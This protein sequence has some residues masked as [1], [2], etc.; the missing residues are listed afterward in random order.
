MLI[1]CV[2]AEWRGPAVQRQRTPLWGDSGGVGASLGVRW[3]AVFP[4]TGGRAA[5]QSRSR[6]RPDGGS[7]ARASPPRARSGQVSMETRR[8]TV[9][10]RGGLE[11]RKPRCLRVAPRRFCRDRLPIFTQHRLDCACLLFPR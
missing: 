5:L 6:E 3:G 4:R 10:N 8:E 11:L 1:W 7:V 9:E 2:C